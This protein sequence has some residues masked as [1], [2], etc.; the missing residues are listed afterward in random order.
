LRIV[1]AVG[2]NA[3]ERPEE[4][5]TYEEQLRNVR[6]ACSEL[7]QLLAEG[8]QLLITHGN[9]PQVGSLA[10]QQ[11]KARADLPAQPLHVL[12]AM[13]QGQI[14][15]MIQQTLQNLAGRSRINKSIISIVTQVLVD[16]S[17]PAFKNPTKPIGPFY[18]LETSERLKA[19]RGYVMAKVKPEGVRVYRR[20][21]PSP[22]PI[23]IIEAE[24]IKRLFDEGGVVVI[25]S[26]GGG[27]PVVKNGEEELEGVDA[28]V[29]KDLAAEKLAEAL[30]AEGLLI[31]T[32]VDGV[33]LDY[34]TPKERSVRRLTVGEAKSYLQEGEFLAGS[35]K[36]K[37]QACIRFA[38]WGGKAAVIA[39]LDKAVESMEGRAGT[40]FTKG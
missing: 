15:Y 11:E 29:D 39:S 12:G 24:E 37:V 3:L 4:R 26:G 32:D 6:V 16:R 21:V 25:A 36:P 20:V 18:D 14:G 38:E 8:H 33:K 19:E 23:R 28:V 27:I 5:G 35:M 1:V 17:D 31:L 7:V 22:E 30:V 10:L 9:G 40:T 13:T 2:G 34:G